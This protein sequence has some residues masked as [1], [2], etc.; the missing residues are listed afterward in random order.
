MKESKALGLWKNKPNTAE[1]RHGLRKSS[2][3]FLPDVSSKKLH[4]DLKLKRLAK[5]ARNSGN[6]SSEKQ[7]GEIVEGKLSSHL[8]DVH[9]K[10]VGHFKGR[11]QHLKGMVNRYAGAFDTEPLETSL[12]GT[13]N[14]IEQETLRHGATL[15]RLQSEFDEADTHYQDFRNTHGLKRPPDLSAGLVGALPIFIMMMVIEAGA[16][17][18]FFSPGSNFGLLG[19]FFYSVII[20][21]L[22]IGGAALFGYAFFRWLNSRSWFRRLLGAFMALVFVG[23]LLVLNVVVGFY[24]SAFVAM[25]GEGGDNLLQIAIGNIMAFEFGVLDEFSFAMMLIGITLGALA[26]AKGARVGDAY[27]GYHR[28]YNFRENYRQRFENEADTL[29]EHLGNLRDKALSDIETFQTHARESI[30]PYREIGKEIG[31]LMSRFDAFEAH[32][33]T[34]GNEVLGSYYKNNQ[35]ASPSNKT[36]HFK[37]QWVLPGKLFSFGEPNSRFIKLAGDSVLGEIMN[38]GRIQNALDK[39]NAMRTRVLETLNRMEHLFVARQGSL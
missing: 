1:G 32:L 29:A 9:E 39:A 31:E 27:P 4:R 14:E 18:F 19:G 25:G 35:L 23:F 24:R 10:G 11:I 20:S 2:L 26:C 13:I 15:E 17:M 5:N 21:V 8:G 16:N 28:I 36:G 12:E 7:V 38:E 3:P 22:N 6:V 37:H 34:V 33:E 30:A